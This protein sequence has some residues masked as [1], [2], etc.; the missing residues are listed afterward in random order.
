[1]NKEKLL[2]IINKEYEVDD[3]MWN[4]AAVTT[5][6]KHILDYTKYLCVV[7]PGNKLKI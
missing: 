3:A 1:M 5:A 4:K 6:E 7:S 2:F